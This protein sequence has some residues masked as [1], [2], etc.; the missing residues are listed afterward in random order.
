MCWPIFLYIFDKDG[1]HGFQPVPWRRCM[2]MIK[3]I[4]IYIVL[5]VLIPILFICMFYDKAMQNSET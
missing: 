1:V 3:Y 2:L 5:G 4:Y